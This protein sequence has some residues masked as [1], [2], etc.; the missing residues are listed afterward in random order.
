M[1]AGHLEVVMTNSTMTWGHQANPDRE[2]KTIQKGERRK[3]QGM[4]KEERVGE[5][6]AGSRGGGV[7]VCRQNS[8]SSFGYA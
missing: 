5:E 2:E 8:N 6:D 4:G 1:W 3:R 7:R